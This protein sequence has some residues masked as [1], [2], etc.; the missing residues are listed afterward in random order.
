MMQANS[1]PKSDNKTHFSFLRHVK[2]SDKTP[3]KV[4]VLAAIIG[5]VVGLIGSLFMLGTEWVSNIR[6]ASVNQYVTNKWLV[7]PAMFVASALLAML[8]YY[9]VK[10]FSPEAGGSGIPEIEGALQD[11]RPVRWWRVIPVKFIGGLGTLGSGMVLGREGPTVQLG[12]NISQMFYDLFRLKDNESRHT[13]LAAGAA[14]GLSTAFN[15]PLAGILFI[16]EEMRPQFKYSLI[17]IKAV[18]IGAVSATIVFRLIN[19]EAAVLNIGQF[20]S[21]PMETLWL[22][23]ILGMLFGIVGIGFNRFLLYL[24][25]LF[26]AFYQNKVSRFVLMGGLIGGS[27][28]AI[29]VFAPEVV[30]GGYSV[31]HQM[32]ANSFTITML[33]VFFALRFLT[34]TI[35][36]SSGAP[37]GIFSPLL[38]L[39]T[40]FGGIYGYAAL[41]LFPNYS[42]EVGTFAIAGMG[43]LFAATVRAPLTGIVLVLEMTNNYQLILPMII[44]CIGATMVAQFLGGRPLYSV[45]LEKTL[46]RSEKQATTSKT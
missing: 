35:S 1:T 41:E 4:L 22:Y 2:E 17:S 5:A 14:A 34:S 44:T 39:G 23:L 11:L 15:A 40:L 37:G 32:V 33:M 28:G 20:S 45:L 18:F 27:C 21:A 3:L 25:S 16:I 10:R 36:F 19:G 9:L 29:G 38:A 13:L 31:I 6:I 7:I 24:Q 8:G 26:L 12:A 42:I 30:G 43:A 46:E